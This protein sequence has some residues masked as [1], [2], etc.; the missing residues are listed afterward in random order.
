MI[1]RI[2][3]VFI[4]ATILLLNPCLRGE[5]TPICI[6]LGQTVNFTPTKTPASSPDSCDMVYAYGDIAYLNK[7]DNEVRARRQ[8][9]GINSTLWDKNANWAKPG[10]NSIENFGPEN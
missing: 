10:S 7:G 5:D 9:A 8:E 2:V 6:Q 4:C 3:K 1:E